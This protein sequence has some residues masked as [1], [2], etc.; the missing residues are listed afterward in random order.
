MVSSLSTYLTIYLY[1][2]FVKQQNNKEKKATSSNSTFHM[3]F[4]VFDIYSEKY[5]FPPLQPKSISNCSRMTERRPLLLDVMQPKQFD[6]T[7]LI[8]QF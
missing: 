6:L 7:D 3:F 2:L 5:F 8:M 4:S 1:P